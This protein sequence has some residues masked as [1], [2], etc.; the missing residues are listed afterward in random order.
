M[1]EIQVPKIGMTF[2]RAL[3]PQIGKDFKSNL[4][5]NGIEYEQVKVDPSDLRSTQSEF[6]MEKVKSMMIGPTQTE[7]DIIISNDDYILDGH[8]RWLAAFNRNK[9]M[10]V[11]KVNLPILELIR[12]SKTFET[13]ECKPIME[14]VKS[15]IKSSLDKRYTK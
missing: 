5:K 14:C 10:T 7:S 3:M 9:K 15:V 4:S 13:T 2:S 8:H 11:L 1:K 6:D 12:L